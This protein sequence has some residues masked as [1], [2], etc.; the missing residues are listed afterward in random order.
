MKPTGRNRALEIS[1]NSYTMVSTTEAKA[2]S[3]R[4]FLPPI[5]SARYAP[6]TKPRNAPR[7]G[8]SRR[9]RQRCRLQQGF[10][11]TIAMPARCHCERSEAISIELCT[12]MEIAASLLTR[13]V[14]NTSSG[15]SGDTFHSGRVG[16]KAGVELAMTGVCQIT[17]N[18]YS[19]MIIGIGMPTAQSKIPRMAHLCSSFAAMIRKVVTM[20]GG[21]MAGASLI[22]D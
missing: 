2:D 16:R 7:I 21:L 13:K 3:I 1:A 5:P 8:T 19:S 20:H 22:G 18:R 4:C 6:V 10:V 14:A 17:W 15:P 9:C 11:Q 12:A